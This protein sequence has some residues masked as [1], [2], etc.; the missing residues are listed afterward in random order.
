LNDTQTAQVTRAGGAPTETTAYHGDS[1]PG[2]ESA[3]KKIRLA[4]VAIAAGAAC[5]AAGPTAA[6]AE[7][8]QSFTFQLENTTADGRFTA[9]FTSRSFDTTSAPPPAMDENTIRLP[10]GV[11]LR[12]EFRRGGYYCDA[13][14]LR[15]AID[16]GKPYSQPWASAYRN[17]G[18]ALRRLARLGTRADRRRIA[19]ARTC[20]R[21]QIGSGRAVVDARPTFTDEIPAD[22]FIYLSKPR[23]GGVASFS[24]VGIPDPKAPV[25]K[26]NT[27][28]QSVRSIVTLN[29]LDDPSADGRFGYKLALPT[30]RI[31]GVQL[32]VS[33][34][35][36]RVPGL[37]L[38]QPGGRSLFWLTRP[39]CPA[40]G[41]LSFEAFYGYAA[42][43]PDITRPFSLPCPR[44]G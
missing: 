43:Q 11:S 33:R 36:V 39:T 12:P 2:E 22:I 28:L 20:V 4:A 37:I 24:I 13:A 19:A 17:P 15:S 44:Y 29:L 9:I 31:E 30:G 3:V 35:E 25:V 26:R 41:Q 10:G 34:L 23:G 18:A 16:A 14:Q 32:S 1:F 5:A 27:I 21:A 6:Q 8:I 42:P 7:P 38:R 40:S